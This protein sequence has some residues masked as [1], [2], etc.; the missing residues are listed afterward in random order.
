MSGCDKLPGVTKKNILHSY[1]AV[2]LMWMSSPNDI[3]GLRETS[4]LFTLVNLAKTNPK[5]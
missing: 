1:L 3:T 4:P 2:N 5:S